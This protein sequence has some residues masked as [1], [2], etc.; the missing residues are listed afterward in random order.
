MDKLG[1]HA[2]NGAFVRMLDSSALYVICYSCKFFCGPVGGPCS[3]QAIR[4]DPGLMDIVCD[5]LFLQKHCQ[6]LS[7]RPHLR[8]WIKG[9]HIAR[10]DVLLFVG[11]LGL[12]ASTELV[13]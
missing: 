4:K 6:E 3:H 5:P 12:K 7:S 13:C 10:G 2:A 11:G 1:V 9:L 8:P